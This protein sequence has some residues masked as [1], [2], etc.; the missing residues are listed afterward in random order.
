MRYAHISFR[1]ELVNS[2]LSLLKKSPF[3]F[4]KESA[5]P[6]NKNTALASI[7]TQTH[8]NSAFNHMKQTKL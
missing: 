8:K 6:S 4:A 2:L 7:K 5:L 3:A 1:Q